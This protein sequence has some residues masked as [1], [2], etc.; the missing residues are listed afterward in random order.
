MKMLAVATFEVK[1][2]VSGG[3]IFGWLYV[4]LGLLFRS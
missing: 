1:V 2:S 3:T 4:I